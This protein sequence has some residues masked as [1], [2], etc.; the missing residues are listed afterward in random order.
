[1]RKHLFA[2]LLGVFLAGGVVITSLAVAAPPVCG[3]RA[4][5][6]E[7]AACVAAECGGLSGKDLST[8]KKQCKA[9]VTVACEEDPTVCNP[10]SPSGAFLE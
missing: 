2:L 7:I 10:P 5:S 8:C 6:E 3:K 4:C 1:M 9:A